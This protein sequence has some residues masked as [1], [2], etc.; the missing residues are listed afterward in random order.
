MTGLLDADMARI[1]HWLGSGWRWWLDELADCVPRRWR[2]AARGKLALVQW[3]D[4]HAS[5]DADRRAFALVLPD[6][7]ALRRTIETPVMGERDLAS[8]IALDARRLMPLGP[9]GAVIGARVIARDG[10]TGR[11]AVEL[12]ALPHPAAQAL[13]GAIAAAPRAP[14]QIW[15]AAPDG[16]GDAPVDLMPA[17]HRAG[18]LTGDARAATRAW[19]IVA[20]LFALNLGVLVWRDAASVDALQAVVDQQAGAVGVAHRVIGRMRAQDRVVAGALAARQSR[21][22]LMV[23]NHLAAALPQATW[24]RKFSLSG[25]TIR[26]SGFHPHGA[27]IAGA[28]RRAGFAVI[29]YGDA[30]EAPTP[31]GEPFD[32]TLGQAS[33][34]TRKP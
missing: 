13:A 25:D 14:A 22:P 17:L 4:A 18:L 27:D 2:R 9:D 33:H 10:Q 20:F 7:L 21:E 8:M 24:L 3:D 1:G 29:R 32:A 6:G 34:Q 5:F 23:M 19:T 11:M 26:I 16:E 15:A 31:L 12:A 28:L 30:G